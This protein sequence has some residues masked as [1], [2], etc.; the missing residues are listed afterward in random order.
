MILTKVNVIGSKY[1]H[2]FKMNDGSIKQVECTKEEY[3][4]LAKVQPNIKDGVWLSSVQKSKCDTKSGDLESGQYFDNGDHNLSKIDG[5][6]M[7]F[8]KT[9]IVKGV[10]SDSK[11]TAARNELV[12]SGL[13]E[14]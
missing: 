2:N 14:M 12:A 11:I 6:V 1:I 10:L 9:D 7:V 5:N 3:E 8:S 13:I 4:N